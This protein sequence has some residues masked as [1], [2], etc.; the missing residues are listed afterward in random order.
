MLNSNKMYFI[1][2]IATLLAFSSQ[3]LANG[4]GGGGG[5]DNDGGLS[6][7]TKVVVDASAKPKKVGVVNTA[8]SRYWAAGLTILMFGHPQGPLLN[9][10]EISGLN[11]SDTSLTNW[12]NSHNN[13]GEDLPES[14]IPELT[15]IIYTGGGGSP[16]D[17]RQRRI[18]DAIKRA[19]TDEDFRKEIEEMATTTDNVEYKAVWDALNS[20]SDAKEEVVQEETHVKEAMEAAKKSQTVNKLL[21]EFGNSKMKGK[22]ATAKGKNP[23]TGLDLT[24]N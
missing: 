1:P 2:I 8:S 12:V 24:T 13:T 3:S 22:L 6:T 18:D 10:E 21:Q 17:G 19:K 5:G 7:K 9:D 20:E 23:K 14:V 4:G 16:T 11:S 15:P